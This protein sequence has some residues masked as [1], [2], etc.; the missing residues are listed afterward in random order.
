METDGGEDGA[1][2]VQM[3]APGSKESR[4]HL[5]F[6]WGR[7]F[8]NVKCAETKHKT[9]SNQ[10]KRDHIC[11]Y[12]HFISVRNDASWLGHAN[13][14]VNWGWC[15]NFFDV[16]AFSMHLAFMLINKCICTGSLFLVLL[17]PPRPP[18]NES[19]V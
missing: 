13:N 2:T 8:R 17:L 11:V 9:Q 5:M 3:S 6:T 18:K 1:E 15:T 19:N 16:R 12:L 10:T 14:Q 7:R 4:Q